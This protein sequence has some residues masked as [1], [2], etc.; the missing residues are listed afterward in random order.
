MEDVMEGY[1][2]EED[3]EEMIKRFNWKN[4]VILFYYLSTNKNLN[5]YFYK[6][7]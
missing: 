4:L 5:P 1:R 7:I 2:E 6:W 3:E